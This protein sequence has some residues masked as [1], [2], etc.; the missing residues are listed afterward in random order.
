MFF[1]SSFGTTVGIYRPLSAYFGS[2]ENSGPVPVPKV[3]LT[4]LHKYKYSSFSSVIGL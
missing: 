1:I 4:Y 2:P 3:P